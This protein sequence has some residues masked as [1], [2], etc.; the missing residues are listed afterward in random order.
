MLR[1]GTACERVAHMVAS[2]SEQA[3]ECTPA[4]L[5]SLFVLMA[6]NPLFDRIQFCVYGQ[7]ERGEKVIHRQAPA[8]LLCES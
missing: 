3:T 2:D 8:L 7:G 1:A 5:M 6:L 4:L